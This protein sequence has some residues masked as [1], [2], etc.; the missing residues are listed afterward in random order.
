[1]TLNFTERENELLQLVAQS[2]DELNIDVYAVG[3]FVRDKILNRDCKD[4]DIV[5]VGSGIEL[6]KKIAE[7]TQPKP[8]VAYFKN[9]GTAQI[10]LPDIE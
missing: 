8:Y 2:A 9:F 5:C 6:A 3:G 1:M 4:I 7:K 10:K